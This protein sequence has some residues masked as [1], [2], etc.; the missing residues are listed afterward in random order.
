MKNALIV[1]CLM[2]VV[3]QTTFAQSPPKDKKITEFICEVNMDLYDGQNGKKADPTKGA[4]TVA[5]KNDT[6]GNEIPDVDDGTVTNFNGKG[7]DEVDLMKLVIKKNTAVDPSQLLLKEISGE[8]KLWRNSTKTN[9]FSLNSNGEAFLV[10]LPFIGNEATLFLEATS[11]STSL[12]D[13]NIQLNRYN[14]GSQIVCDN[15]SATA[16][17]F[18]GIVKQS[19]NSTTPILGTGGTLPDLDNARIINNINN[20][21][22]SVSGNRWGHGLFNKV[23]IPND[24]IDNLDKRFGGRILFE[25]SVLPALADNQKYINID[26]TRQKK[27]RSHQMKHGDAAIL[28]D[29]GNTFNFP[30]EE[31]LNNE[32]P[33]D[34]GSTIDEDN[35]LKNNHIYSIDVPSTTTKQPSDLAFLVRLMTFKEFVRISPYSLGTPGV[36]GSLGSRASAKVPWSCFIY[37]KMGTGQRFVADNDLSSNS[38][39]V[40]IAGTG[41]NGTISVTLGTNVSNSSFQLFIVNSAGVRNGILKNLVTGQTISSL[42]QNGVCSLNLNGIVIV[43]LTDGSMPFAIDSSWKFNTFTTSQSQKENILTSSSKNVT[44]DP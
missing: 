29:A 44:I 43:K 18:D 2:I 13:I 4:V 35:S 42:F 26:I 40:K 3:N 25:F 15:E 19:A 11:T 8:F 21:Y 14:A 5:N 34:D 12:K 16:F 32:L 24:P 22:I 17:W 37:A 27:V 7:R 9:S 31:N 6:N 23:A 20:V 38:L 1:S 10:D 33:N 30:E 28:S 41:G 39:P 36:G